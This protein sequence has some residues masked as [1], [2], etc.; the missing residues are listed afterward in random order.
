MRTI[1]AA[2]LVLA[3]AMG[4]G[5]VSMGRAQ[6][7]ARAKL[8]GVW[9]GTV[10]FAATAPATMEFTQD[11][12]TVRWKCSFRTSSNILWGDAE[13][14]VTSFSFPRLE[15]SGVYTKHS[16]PGGVGTGL[17]FSLTLVGDQLKGTATAEM[18]NIPAQVSLT[19]Q[20]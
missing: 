20:K 19:R 13:G 17:K 2:S 14:A 7:E 1:I 8:L 10:N 15:A 3:V 6:D 12:Q 18:N 16:V 4:L 5:G 11:G 9:E